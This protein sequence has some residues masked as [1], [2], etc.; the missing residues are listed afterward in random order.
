MT[1]YSLRQRKPTNYNVAKTLNTMVNSAIEA[2]KQKRIK[3][4]K[5]DTRRRK[6]KKLKENK[7]LIKKP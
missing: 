2:A 1:K 6:A 7:L 4:V 5:D 3:K